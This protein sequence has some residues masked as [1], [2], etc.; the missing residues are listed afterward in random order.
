MTVPGDVGELIDE[1]NRFVGCFQYGENKKIGERII[2]ALTRCAVLEQERDSL[3]NIIG[4][5]R[6]PSDGR[7]FVGEC[8]QAKAC[9][10]SIGLVIAALTP[11]ST[12]EE[13]G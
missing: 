7:H 12:K 8:V 2:A 10:C 5:A 3:A 13:R 1:F 9:G 11:T 6:C 4:V